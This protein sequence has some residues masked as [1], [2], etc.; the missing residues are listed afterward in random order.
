MNR[1][2]ANPARDHPPAEYVLDAEDFGESLRERRPYGHRLKHQ[3]STDHIAQ[4]KGAPKG[5]RQHV[6][7]SLS[8]ELLGSEPG[9]GSLHQS[10]SAAHSQQPIKQISDGEKQIAGKL[11]NI[12]T[13]GK[14]AKAS[15][16]PRDHPQSSGVRVRF[17][18]KA[19]NTNS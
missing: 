19:R 13:L 12:A 16:D 7:R 5:E 1:R 9:L 11:L 18:E 4:E 15:T 2:P 14:G 6:N 10:G 8:A 3:G 17:K